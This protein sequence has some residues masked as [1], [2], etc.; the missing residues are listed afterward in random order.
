MHC[1]PPKTPP[2]TLVVEDVAVFLLPFV[3]GPVET[4]LAF[5]VV[6][7]P[8]SEPPID[9]VVHEGVH[10]LLEGGE[11]VALLLF[12]RGHGER[13]GGAAGGLRKD[14]ESGGRSEERRDNRQRGPQRRGFHSVSLQRR[15]N[16]ASRMNERVLK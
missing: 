7:C 2:L 1:T 14:G 12:R 3:P 10:L 4:A 13:G 9:G 8:G 16:G 5:A 11:N 6:L 15:K